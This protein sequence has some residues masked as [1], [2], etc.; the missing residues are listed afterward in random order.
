MA[1]HA[2]NRLPRSSIPST[3]YEILTVKRPN[4]SK[5]RMFGSRLCARIPGAG[6]FP[7]LDHTNTNGIFLGF[8]ATDNNIYFEDDDSG[9]VLI[10]TY[11]LFDEAHLSVAS[12]L[13]PL[14]SQALQRS[15]YSPADDTDQTKHIQLK[16]LS[17]NA[18]K[19]IVSTTQS[20]GINLHSAIPDTTIIPPNEIESIPT[21]LAVEPPPGTYVRLA[22]RSSLSFKHNVHI[23]GGVIDPE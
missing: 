12:N 8:T 7:K 21:Y 11:V 19:P 6:K 18:T 9:K 2:K 15:G 13:A 16:L 10:I 17:A 14:G 22:S 20:I 5:L 4:V 23:V 1:V 3:P